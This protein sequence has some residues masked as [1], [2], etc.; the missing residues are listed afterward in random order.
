MTGLYHIVFTGLKDRVYY[1]PFPPLEFH[2]PILGPSGES[3]IAARRGDGALSVVAVAVAIMVIER[4]KIAALFQ[5][6]YVR[7]LM[8][9]KL[10]E[11]LDHDQLGD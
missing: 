1:A 4:E 6:D 5:C 7:A 8:G 3:V 2:C 9:Q 10:R 11:R